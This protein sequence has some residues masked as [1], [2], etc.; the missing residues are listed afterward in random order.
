M[1]SFSEREKRSEDISLSPIFLS[2]QCITPH[3]F[4]PNFPLYSAN[5]NNEEIRIACGSNIRVT[6]ARSRSSKR[7]PVYFNDSWW[8]EQANAGPGRHKTH[9]FVVVTRKG[10][11]ER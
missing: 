10:S 2:H 6:N 3:I 4:L 1:L 8:V 9:E 7:F 5:P 11:Y